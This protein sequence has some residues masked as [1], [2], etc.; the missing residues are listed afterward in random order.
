MVRVMASALL[1]LTVGLAGCSEIAADA[2]AQPARG[3]RI[4]AVA[5]DGINS[6]VVVERA[7]GSLRQCQNRPD[8]RGNASAWVCRDLPPLPV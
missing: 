2:H 1:M 5:T 6:F 7:D 3:Q 4:A 8:P